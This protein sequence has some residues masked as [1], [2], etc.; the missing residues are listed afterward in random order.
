MPTSFRWI[1]KGRLAGSGQPG[2]LRPIDEDLA[3]LRAA[4][5]RV[6][7]T[8]TERPLIPPATES[9]MRF[10]HFPIADMGIP[11]PRD[12]ARLCREVAASLE[13]GEAVLL[14]CKAGMGRTG[15][16]LACCLVTLGRTPAQALEEVRRANAGYV[17]SVP[18]A[19]FIS[20][21]GE[22]LRGQ[23]EKVTSP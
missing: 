23:M 11:T 21:Y 20:H 8:L 4:G 3:F 2:L 17:Q 22:Y 14:H 15:T 12:G 19:Q 9:G 13:R 16:M 6:V 5:I 18:Q 10:L 7:V 1:L